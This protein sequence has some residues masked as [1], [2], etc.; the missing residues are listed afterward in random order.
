MLLD[1]SEAKKDGTP[2][3]LYLKDPIP[4]RP[5]LKSWNGLVFIGRHPGVAEDGFDV[6]WS[7]SAPVG[8]GGFPDYWF[9]GWLPIPER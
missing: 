3:L 7:F 1:M 8:Q 2:I 6:G 9:D 4:D 5:D